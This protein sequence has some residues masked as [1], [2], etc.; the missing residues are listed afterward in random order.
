MTINYYVIDDGAL[1]ISYYDYIR[2]EPKSKARAYAEIF[3][4]EEDGIAEYIA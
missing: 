4:N 1:L 2:T 3:I